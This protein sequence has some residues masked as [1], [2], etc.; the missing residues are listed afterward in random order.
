MSA[1]N[2]GS[3][4]FENS[5]ISSEE[6]AHDAHLTHMS[7]LCALVAALSFALHSLFY[8]LVLVH[9]EIDLT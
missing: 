2:T 7:I 8:K 4:S 5:I 6:A 3:T 9:F 1:G